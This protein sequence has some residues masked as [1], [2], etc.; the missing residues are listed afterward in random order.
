MG[1]LILKMLVG[2]VAGLLIWMIFE[3]L[4]PSFA[5]ASWAAWELKFIF[6]LGLAIGL[7]VGALNGWI[8]GSKTHLLRGAGLGLLF[9]GIGASLGYQIGGNLCTGIFGGA[10]FVSPD[11][12]IA[13]KTL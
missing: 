9:G 8:Q 10:V 2:A 13:T 5:S 7:A 4:A 3:P 11:V 12:S 1:Q 6:C